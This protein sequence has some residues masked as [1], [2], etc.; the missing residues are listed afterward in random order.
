M[1]PNIAMST[2][3]VAQAFTTNS[4]DIE[5]DYYTA[6]DDSL[7]RWATDQNLIRSPAVGEMF[8]VAGKPFARPP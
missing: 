2:V 1:R 5:D 8:W 7:R 3:Q 4:V 6:V